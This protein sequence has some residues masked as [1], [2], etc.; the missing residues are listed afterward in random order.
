MAGLVLDLNTD[1]CIRFL[2]LMKV[3]IYF[4][5]YHQARKF[6]TV[7]YEGGHSAEPDKESVN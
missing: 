2:Q 6:C 7:G 3:E 5:L 4:R 1:F